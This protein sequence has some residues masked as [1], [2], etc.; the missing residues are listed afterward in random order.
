[1]FNL[2]L[3]RA[4]F[5]QSRIP[6][7][8]SSIDLTMVQ[9]NPAFCEFVGYSPDELEKLSMEK[10]SHPDDMAADAQLFGELLDRKRDEYQ[11]EKRYIHKSG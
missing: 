3:F 7:L 6:Q 2:T 11:L 9:F 4:V 10:I 5:Y 8:I 1:M